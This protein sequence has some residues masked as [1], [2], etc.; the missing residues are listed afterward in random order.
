MAITT[1]S[2]ISVKPGR[3][4]GRMATSHEKG[5]MKEKTARSGKRN[6]RQVREIQE[7]HAKV[8]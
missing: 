2:S 1:K 4:R 8:Y 6:Y 3:V 5:K 7:P